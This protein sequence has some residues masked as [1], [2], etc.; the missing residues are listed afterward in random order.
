MSLSHQFVN[1]IK[2]SENNTVC[3]NQQI[4]KW[5]CNK[6]TYNNY[7]KAKK[8]TMCGESRSHCLIIDPFS[9]KEQSIDIYKVNIIIIHF[10]YNQFYFHFRW[11]LQSWITI[12]RRKKICLIA[13]IQVQMLTVPNGHVIF[14]HI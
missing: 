10:H 8:C 14:V 9:S 3:N 13:Q 12:V 2:M 6:C 5:T 1:D 11:L 4:D 7:P